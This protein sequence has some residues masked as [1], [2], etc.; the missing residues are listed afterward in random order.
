[1]MASHRCGRRSGEV[2]VAKRRKWTHGDLDTLLVRTESGEL[3]GKNSES[4]AA[5]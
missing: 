5:V 4:V 1:V 3:I 2:F